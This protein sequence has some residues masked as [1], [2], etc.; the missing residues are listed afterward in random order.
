MRTIKI[1][2]KQCKIELTQELLEI[3][4]ENLCWEDSEDI[5]PKNNFSV[6]TNEQSNKKFIVVAIDNYNLINH[7]DK[8]RFHGCC[9]S[10]GSNGLNKLCSNGHEVATEFSDCWT[11]HYIEFNSDK[12]IV[13]GKI[14][15]EFK[16]F[17][18]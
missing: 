2:C 4:E 18:L 13:K 5:M 17:K 3:E 7:S 6:L 9:G 1:Y 16:E 8:Y 14:N 12:V 11:G 10:D 15:D